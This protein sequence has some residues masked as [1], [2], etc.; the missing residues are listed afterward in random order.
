MG[1]WLLFVI[2]FKVGLFTIGGGLASVGLLHEYLV[3]TN[4]LNSEDFYNMFAISQST[5]GP[6]GVNMATFVGFKYAGVAGGIVATSAL[7]LPSLIIITLLAYFLKATKNNKYISGIFSGCRPAAI[8]IVASVAYYVLENLFATKA[9][10]VYSSYEMIVK[11]G[12]FVLTVFMS[13]KYS[14]HPILCLLIGGVGALIF[15]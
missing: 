10:V 13:I 6:I 3:E 8:G 5:P 12:I 14:L 11:L 9:V 15:I 2:F 7:V 4:Y 1:Y